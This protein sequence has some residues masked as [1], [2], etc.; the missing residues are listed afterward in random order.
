VEGL[1][2]LYEADA[3]PDLIVSDIMMPKMDGYEFFEKVRAEPDWVK[4]PFIFLTAKG[5]K[6]DIRLGKGLGVDDY[7]TKPFDS[8]DVLVAVS[9]RL[10]RSRQLGEVQQVEMSGLKRDI[11]TILNHEFRTPLTY[12]VAYAD[13]VS[14]DKEELSAEEFSSFLHG[15][16]AGAGRI[17]KLVENFI[18]LVELETGE[19]LE[20]FKWRRTPIEQ[21]DTILANVIFDNTTEAEAH[22]ITLKT[23]V[24][25]PPPVI[26]GDEEYLHRALN[27]LVENAIKFTQTSG[28]T[29]TI[30]VKTVG[31]DVHLSVTD[32]GRGIEQNELEQIFEPFYQVDREHYEDQGAG[33]GLAIV[34]GIADMHGGK[35]LAQS[36][37]GKGSDFSVAIPIATEAAIKALEEEREAEDA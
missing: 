26:I 4:I 23:E 5:E 1:E 37:F 15:I 14:R 27:H 31:D 16:E 20:T 8:D 28:G 29:I 2:R 7:V 36:E 21:Y 22:N 9:S 12:I 32:D 34:R 30:S 19:A 6:N 33:S 25:E 24:E 3:P 17:R 35:T 11:L 10:Q 13:M 18:F